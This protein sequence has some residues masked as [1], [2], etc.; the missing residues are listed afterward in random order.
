MLVVTAKYFPLDIHD[1]FSPLF[2]Q[3]LVFA[4][5]KEAQAVKQI[6]SPQLKQMWYPEVG[7]VDY[8]YLRIFFV[9]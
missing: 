3:S 7:A 5:R 4:I 6:Y 9:T 8:V 1:G 2:R